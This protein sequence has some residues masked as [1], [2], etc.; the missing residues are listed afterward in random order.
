MI[1]ESVQVLIYRHLDDV[2]GKLIL[3]AAEMGAKFMWP[4]RYY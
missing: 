3:G 4:L 1:I 2:P